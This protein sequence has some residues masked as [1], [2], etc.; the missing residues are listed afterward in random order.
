[1]PLLCLAGLTR[2]MAD[3]EDFAAHY[4]D[5][6][7]VIRLDARGRGL[8]DR[9]ADPMTYD[10]PHEA[11]D[12]LALLDHLGI[13][14]AV[15]FGT[16]RGGLLTMAVAAT[17]PQR[18]RAAIL[19]DIGPEIAP[20]GIA[21]IMDYVGKSPTADTLVGLAEALRAGDA[22]AA[23][24]LTG[25]DWLKIAARVAEETP[26][27]LQWRYDLR[28]RD[29]LLAQAEALQA[30]QADGAPPPDLWPMFEALAGRPVLVLR[31]ANSDLL[32]AE[33]LAE[34]QA[35]LPGMAAVTVPDRGHV[36]LLDEPESLAA[37]DALLARAADA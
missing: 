23:P 35:R 1:M 8:S 33:T 5:R 36:P 12:A 37:I 18:V 24:T 19:N 29:A 3:F 15:F 34:M 32:S 4:A 25:A 31:G 28:L 6:F 30:A 2:N 10:V 22:G 13:E 21:R 9:P 17:A 16:S 26:G 7:R 27:G 14:R 11:R 20:G